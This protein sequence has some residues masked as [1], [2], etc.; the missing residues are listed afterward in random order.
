MDAIPILHDSEEESPT[1]KPATVAK[2]E[3]GSLRVRD[4]GYEMAATEDTE[5]L[6]FVEHE[7]ICWQPQEQAPTAR[8]SEAPL[9][10]YHRCESRREAAP[11]ER[12]AG[13]QG[14]QRRRPQDP[15]LLPTSEEEEGGHRMGTEAVGAVGE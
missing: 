14:G 15:G 9:A 7:D 1:G 8:V 11:Q 2:N 10:T 4:T 3:D 5:Y 12:A 13:Q 6:S